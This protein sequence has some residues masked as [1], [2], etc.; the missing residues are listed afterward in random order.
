[1]QRVLARYVANRSDDRLS[2]GSALCATCVDV[3]D[4]PGAGISLGRPGGDTYTLST[5]NLVMAQLQ[6]LE[7]VLGEGPCTDAFATGEPT[8][9]ADLLDPTDT[10]WLGFAAGAL[11]TEARASFAY[12]LRVDATPFGS[13]NLY[14]AQAGALQPEQHLDALVLA[15]VIAHEVLIDQ[16]PPT[17]G[18][19]HP[20]AR[21]LALDDMEVHQA[22]GM[23]S[24]Q[25]AGSITD[26]HSRLRARA[27][28]DDRPIRA[29]AADVV[30]RR[31]RFSP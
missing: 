2:V 10:R 31:L 11:M 25:V 19:E 27:F 6:E 28:A 16:D 29:V 14:A 9:K 3:L 13:L 4:L 22:V 26:A 15:D 7:R 8:A 30:A 24:V 1:V 17:G 21:D 5:S 23:I 18:R 12:P 20:G